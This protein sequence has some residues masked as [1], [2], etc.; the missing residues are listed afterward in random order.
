MTDGGTPIRVL[1]VDDSD[2][3]RDSLVFLLSTR[4]G[5][6]VV[7]A[8]RDGEAAIRAFHVHKPEVVVLDYRLPG[9]DGVEATMAVRAECP[10]AAVVC[11]TASA[12]A[13]EML[14]LREAGAVA[15]LRKDQELDEIV[16]AIRRAA[17]GREAA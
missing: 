16:R 3:Y 1:L 12:G 10:T 8:V 7:D 14:A 2:V 9:M 4:A 11:L 15:C 6:D 13:P 5:I 17:D